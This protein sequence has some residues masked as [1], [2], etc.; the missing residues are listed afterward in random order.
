LISLRAGGMP[1][2]VGKLLTRNT[3]LLHTSSQSEVFTQSY[4]PL[5]LRESQLWEFRDSHSGVPKQN[6]IWVLVPWP[7]TKYT[8]RGK[9]VASPKFE[10]WWVCVCPW[11][12]CAPKCSKYTLTNLLFSLC[13]SVWV[14]EFLV[15]LSS[16]ILKLQH[17]FLPSKCCEPRNVLQLLFFLL[18]SLLDS[19]LSPSRSLGV[20]H[21][22]WTPTTKAWGSFNMLTKKEPNE[23]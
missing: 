17:T 9:V 12:A 11:F 5:K 2:T 22:C 14:I 8:I 6:A 1:H 16:L 13:R 10:L 3:T 15:N 4:G 7:S 20:C 21:W 18:S 19:H 23:L